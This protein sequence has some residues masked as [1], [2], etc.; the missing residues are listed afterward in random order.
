MT[1]RILVVRHASAGDR[2]QWEGDDRQ[3]PLDAKGERQAAAITPG[4]LAIAPAGPVI[5]S[6]Y[7]RCVLTVRALAG[8]RGV[9]IELSDD[10]AEGTGLRVLD[11]ARRA[12]DGAALCTHGDVMQ[13]LVS[14][15]A[16]QGLIKGE[17]SIDKGATWM[18]ELDGE[19]VTGTTYLPVPKLKST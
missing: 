8:A 14:H 17:A 3:R 6:P 2:D 11:V 4:L 19:R 10:L 13:E 5:S 16:R 18:L 1:R 15:L 7:A 12:A 9:E